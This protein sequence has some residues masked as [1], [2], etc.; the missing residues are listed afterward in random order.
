MYL[1]VRLAVTWTTLRCPCAA[2][3]V[4]E[5]RGTDQPGHEEHEVSVGQSSPRWGRRALHLGNRETVSIISR[6]P[7]ERVASMTPLESLH[8][9]ANSYPESSLSAVLI[10]VLS[11]RIRGGT[12]VS[13]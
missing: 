7:T 1:R 2:V 11:S 4:V 13:T 3:V 9:V 12:C 5:D 6:K 8:N 10:M